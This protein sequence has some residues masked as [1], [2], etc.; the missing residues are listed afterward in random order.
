[1]ELPLKG[2]CQC[3]AVRYEIRAA[4][5]TLYVCH[6]TDCQRQSGSAF[7]MSMLVPRDALV[8][9]AGTP[10]EWQR[11]HES[12]RLIDCVFCGDCGT[13]LYHKPTRA[14]QVAILK[15]GTL[16]EARSLSPV[17]HIWT[18]SAQAWVEIPEDAVCYD[19][20]PADLTR[21]SEAW[22]TA[23]APKG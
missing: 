18:R 9:T 4:P 21:L 1:M 7:S 12:G 8:I 16:D 5:S 11:R 10:R 3:G 19:A 17:G 2:G 14:P 15:P 23:Q 20:Q 22:Q 6:C 13:R